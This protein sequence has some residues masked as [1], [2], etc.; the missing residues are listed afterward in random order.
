LHKVR[1]SIGCTLSPLPAL[2]PNTRQVGAE[3]QGEAEAGAETQAQA[4]TQA[5]AEGKAKEKDG[6]EGGAVAGL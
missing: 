4:Q 5:K 1:T 6:S 2:S 3:G